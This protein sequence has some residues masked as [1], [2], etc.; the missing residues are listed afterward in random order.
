[1]VN[2][3]SRS[4][5]FSIH[6]IHLRWSSFF[7]VCC[8]GPGHSGSLAC[9][10]CKN[11]LTSHQAGPHR[12]HTMAILA[13]VEPLDLLELLEHS[14]HASRTLRVT[15]WTTSG[16]LCL[17]MCIP[18][19]IGSQLWLTDVLGNEHIGLKWLNLTVLRSSR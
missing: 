6:C 12:C 13:P 18:N 7:M 5:I 9:F 16:C 2:L 15:L 19:V 10:G 4:R 14:G 11:F 17:P 8:L 1:M 3:R